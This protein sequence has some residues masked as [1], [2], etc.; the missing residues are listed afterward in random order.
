MFSFPFFNIL[1]SLVFDEVFY[2]D[3]SIVVSAPTGSGKTVI[4]ELALIRL[5]TKR[6]TTDHKG[7]VVYMAPM[8]ALCS[9]R[10]QDWT[11]KFS[12][13]GITCLQITGDSELDD[14]GDLLQTDLICTTP[15]KWDSMSRRWRDN[16]SLFHQIQLFLID[17]IHIL[18]DPSRGATVEAVVSRM[19]TLH[20][21]NPHAGGSSI[22][23]VAA[24]ATVPNYK[25]IATW[26]GTSCKPAAAF[27]LGEE[28]RPVKLDRIVLGYPFKEGS[29]DF[30]FDMYLSYRLRAIIETYS[31]G[32]P[33][34][35]FCSSRKSVI[36]TAEVL[37]KS[38]GVRTFLP[39]SGA[40]VV[41]RAAN[42]V[43]ESKLGDLM[44]SGVGMHHAGMDTRDRQLVEELFRTSQLPVLI[45]TSTLAMGVNLPAHLV[46][47]KSTHFYNLGVVQEYSNMQ[48]LQ[49]IGRAG[50]PQFDTSATAVIMTKTGIKAKYESLVNGTQLIESSLH[51]NLIEHLNAEIVLQTISEMSLVVEWIRHTF[52]YVRVMKNPKYYGLPANLSTSEVE[53]RLTDLCQKSLAQL[54]S[55]NLVSVNEATS[56]IFP[57]STGRLMARFCISY[58]TMKQFHNI[59]DNDQA[60]I[61]DM[62]TVMSQCSEFED[63]QLRTS[64]KKLL[65][66]FNRDKN[67]E[68]IRFPMSGKIKT[69]EMKVN[70]LIQAQ[71][72]CLP[73]QDF[74]LSQD[75][76]KIFRVGQRIAK[77]LMEFM[78]QKSNYSL[79]L[80]AVL[81][82]KAFKSKLWYDSRYV[83]R[84]LDGIGPA[85][86]LALANSGLTSFEKLEEANP[87]EIEV[88]VNRHPPFGNQ[89]KEAISAL[90]K[91]ELG[92]EQ[93][94]G[95]KPNKAVVVL[96]VSLL[97]R[98]ILETRPSSHNTHQSLLIVGD[99]ENH[100]IFKCR[101]S[102]AAIL[103]LGHWSQTL[104][105]KRSS[106][107]AKLNISLL[108][109]DWVGLDIC[110]EY[111]PVYSD[112]WFQSTKMPQNQKTQTPASKLSQ[113]VQLAKMKTTLSIQP[114]ADT[115]VNDKSVKN[116][117]HKC[118]DKST[119]GHKCC[120]MNFSNKRTTPTA[121]NTPR[122]KVAKREHSV[123]RGN[124]GIQEMFDIVEQR[125][126]LGSMPRI[127]MSR[128][129]GLS[130]ALGKATTSNTLQAAPTGCLT[131]SWAEDE[132][133]SEFDDT[134]DFIDVSQVPG[135]SEIQPQ[136]GREH[137][138]REE[139]SG[140]TILSLPGTLHQEAAADPD[141][142]DGD[143]GG[144]VW[145]TTTSSD[146]ELCQIVETTAV[147]ATDSERCAETTC[148][149]TT[150]HMGH[151]GRF[152]D[153]DEPAITSQAMKTKLG[154]Q[155]EVA[156]K[157]YGVHSNDSQN[158]FSVSSGDSQIRGVSLEVRSPFL[159]AGKLSQPVTP[160]LQSSTSSSVI[161]SGK[162]NVDVEILPSG[163]PDKLSY[164]EDDD[165]RSSQQSHRYGRVQA[166]KK[167]SA[168]RCTSHD[169]SLNPACGLSTLF[170]PRQRIA[171]QDSN[172]TTNLF[173]G[174][175]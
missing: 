111:E 171:S 69:K 71:L 74:S 125:G 65:N 51:K 172:L 141:D 113:A 1:Q 140:N 12:R 138:Q 90:P 165:D 30:R 173:E 44:M 160:T 24:S 120:K 38:V 76:S 29:S 68:T 92:V 19:K 163:Y 118:L 104:E 123:V 153:I 86:S 27:N 54:S 83:A 55:L 131:N 75:M 155:S 7:K 152:D 20:T 139:K 154:A 28:F 43:H 144:I 70:C 143:M 158:V 60:S 42:T 17:E 8:K 119:C 85:M 63:I 48:I 108:S 18:N 59:E 93:L 14:F 110:V 132:F 77:C 98:S 135:H 62:L 81:I 148:R 100:L 50:R 39:R 96:S 66:A 116:C 122:A 61:A 4:F 164:D 40:E 26:L 159:Y 134:D 47:I 64:E 46:V 35:V 72:S 129:P 16:R 22:R 10:Y 32:K 3:R 56:A 37:V 21:A 167:S 142:V 168:K 109:Q 117:S 88:I 57:T 95:Y 128:T 91:Y 112:G 89:V 53:K 31:H 84:Q 49:M 130:V 136:V 161:L 103:R 23:F 41:Q 137:L 80:H 133:D 175:F 149:N 34:L 174:I 87:R 105:V 67:R 6:D 170:V 102:D 121:V 2:T 151:P 79:L 150:S 45:S 9:E 5:L 147:P 169:V 78:Y 101:I 13:H 15:E 156:C 157:L 11:A 36:Q 58:E 115:P 146:E 99:A 94:K 145:S 114:P 97:N 52:L 166:W 107:G 82:Y 126:F 106:R 73:V 162:Q 127:S 124:R 33:T 25:D